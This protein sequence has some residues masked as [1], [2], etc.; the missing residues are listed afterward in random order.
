MESNLQEPVIETR[1][2]GILGM[3]CDH[4]VR[5]VEKTLRSQD[6]V[7]EVEVNRQESRAT[8]RFDRSKT[9]I[10][11]LHDALLKSGYTPKAV[12]A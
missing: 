8:I 5:K 11:A 7:K 1:T 2:I 12:P 9:D 6:G 3:T 10:P 4:C